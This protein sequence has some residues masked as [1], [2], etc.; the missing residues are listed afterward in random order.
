MKFKSEIKNLID[1]ANQII[2]SAKK[3]LNNP[4]ITKEQI[5]KYLNDVQNKYLNR[6]ESLINRETDQ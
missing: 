4:L 6:I 5:E 2:D 1:D 3:S